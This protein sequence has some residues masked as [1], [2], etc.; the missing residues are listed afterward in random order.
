MSQNKLINVLI[1]ATLLLQVTVY[2]QNSLELEENIGN[3]LLSSTTSPSST[4]ELN[5]PITVTIVQS[6]E[7]NTVPTSKVFPSAIHENVGSPKIPTVLHEATTK[8]SSTNNRNRDR[9]RNR[10]RN[11]NRDGDT[12]SFARGR[13]FDPN[14]NNPDKVFFRRLVRLGS[15]FVARSL[16]LVTG[17]DPQIESSSED[18]FRNIDENTEFSPF[19]G[20]VKNSSQEDNQQ[21]FNNNKWRNVNPAQLLQ[22]RFLIKQNKM[23]RW[24]EVKDDFRRKELE[25]RVDFFNDNSGDVITRNAR[26]VIR[27]LVNRFEKNTET[28]QLWVDYRRQRLQRFLQMPL[29]SSI[30]KNNTASITEDDNSTTTGISSSSSN[31]NDQDDVREV[32]DVSNDY[33]R[34]FNPI[35]DISRK[36]MRFIQSI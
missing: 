12:R 15:N 29:V 31:E 11:R 14:R 3:S 32:D 18:R 19:I 26:N 8:L 10:S 30:L 2:C 17:N 34:P 22:S 35:A 25:R 28:M 23:Q 6:N 9:S 21:F 7:E 27:N 16:G 36:V 33:Y 24:R 20:S 4:H 13:N 1:S 5:T